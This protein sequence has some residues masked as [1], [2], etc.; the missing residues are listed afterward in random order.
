MCYCLGYLA[1][2]ISLLGHGVQDDAARPD[3]IGHGAIG[4]AGCG[5]VEVAADHGGAA[6]RQWRLGGGNAVFTHGAAHDGVAVGHEL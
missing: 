6:A 5:V 3:Q 4:T 2:K 1:L